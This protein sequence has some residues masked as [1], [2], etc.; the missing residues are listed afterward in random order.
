MTLVVDSAPAAAP[1]RAYPRRRR[2]YRRRAY[3][4]YP[5]RRYGSY[6]R[7]SYRRYGRGRRSAG[8]GNAA[9][10]VQKLPKF[11]A[12][13]IDPFSQYV[14]GVKIPDSNTY[15]STA[16]RLEDTFTGSSDA[17]GL[18]ARL[19]RPHP[20]GMN[21]KHTAATASTWTWSAAYGGFDSSVRAASLVAQYGLY[22]S[23]AHGVR[24]SCLGAPTSVTG[25]LHVA[26]VAASDYNQ[27]TWNFP[28]SLTAM[29]NAMFYRK[30]PL[31]MFTQQNLNIVNKY[32]DC[33]QSVYIDANTGRV[34]NATDMQFHTDGWAAILLVI[35]GA[36]INTSLLTIE[37][38]LHLEAIP[39]TSSIDSGTPAAAYNTS[40]LE[41]VS[42][43]AGQTPAAFAD[44]EHQSYF[45]EVAQSIS[46]GAYQAGNAL[47]NN[48][49]LPGLQHAAYGATMYAA[50][51]VRG[52]PGVTNFRSESGFARLTPSM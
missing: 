41:E 11:L 14:D 7:R 34:A 31:A 21:V 51:Q 37:N 24:V 49:V 33:S 48:V 13:Q 16:I 10:A 28:T 8:G 3:S 23:V 20:Y 26:I 35:E 17:N 39:L 2:T 44:Q 47:F 36:P 4:R 40:V 1:S 29:S 5:R 15:P 22:R 46:R 9:M 12:A 18:C 50:N 32:L 38:V 52:I 19:L 45:D 6:R 43:M 42:R 30:Y 27:A 25:N